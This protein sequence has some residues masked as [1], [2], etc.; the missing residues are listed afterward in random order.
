MVLPKAISLFPGTQSGFLS[1]VS[2]KLINGEWNPVLVTEVKP[3][4][5]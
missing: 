2:R 1:I 3:Q 4:E 5:N